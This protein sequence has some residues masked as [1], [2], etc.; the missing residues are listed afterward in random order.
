MFGPKPSMVIFGRGADGILA[1]A[2]LMAIQEAA[3]S[4]G[5]VVAR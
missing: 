4:K 3:L 5:N 2:D 1:K